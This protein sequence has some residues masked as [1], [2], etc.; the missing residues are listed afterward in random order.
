[1]IVGS[2]TMTQF[3]TNPAVPVARPRA[4]AR[5]RREVGLHVRPYEVMIIL[6]AGLEEEAIRSAVDRATELI[7]SRGGNPGSID[8]WGRR[9]FAYELKHKWEGY[10]V[11]LRAEAEPSVMSELDRSLFLADEVLRHKVIRLPDDVAAAAPTAAAPAAGA[12][13]NGA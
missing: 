11:V 4:D 8:R 7:R 6:D 3:Q 9:R 2:T 5:V 10:Y 12:E 13:A 1:M